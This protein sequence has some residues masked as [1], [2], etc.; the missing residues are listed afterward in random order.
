METITRRG[1][2]LFAAMGAIWGIPYLLIKVAVK[3]LEPPVV[4]FGRTSIAAVVLVALA[5]RADAL[6]PALAQWRYVLLFA[7]MEMAVPWFLLTNAERHLPSGLS[8]LLVSCVPLVGAVAAFALG[9]RAAL[10]PIR[11]VAIGLGMAG[12]A[13]LVARDLGGADGIPWLSVGSVLLVCVG[14]ATAPFLATRRLGDVPSIGVIAVSLA[15]V[16]IVYAPFAFVT[17]PAH[18]PPASALWAVLGL[19]VICTGIAFVLFFQLITAI[20]PERATLITFVNPAVAVVLGAV[21]LDERI[22]VSTVIGFVLVLSGCW[23]ATR[24]VPDHPQPRP[25]ESDARSDAGSKDQSSGPTSW[26]ES[27]RSAMVDRS[28]SR[29]GGS[30]PPAP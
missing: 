12:V 13:L 19:A 28:A 29:A 27:S 18:T 2:L 8:G 11:L 1:W 14:Y 9:D 16:A 22:T 4:V 26:S 20:G 6:R 15:F 17:R 21:L 23:L 24:R 7:T 3:H 30:R 25:A 5:W 10:R